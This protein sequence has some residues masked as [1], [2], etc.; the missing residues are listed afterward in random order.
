MRE[1]DASI[2]YGLRGGGEL[3]VPL[4]LLLLPLAG[5]HKTSEQAVKKA[6]SPW[7]QHFKDKMNM[8]HIFHN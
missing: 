1:R 2:T 5:Q 7:Y 6:N 3:L 4:L 8:Q